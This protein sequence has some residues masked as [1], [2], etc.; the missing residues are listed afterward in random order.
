[1]KFGRMH[2]KLLLLFQLALLWSFSGL[3]FG[4]IIDDISLK[5]DAKGELDAVITF[6]IPIQYLRHFPHKKTQEMVIYFNIS[7]SVSRDQWQNYES[8]RSPPSDIV[9]AVYVSTR[10]LAT[11]PKIRFQFNRPAEFSVAPGRNGQSILV[12][13]KPEVVGKQKNGTSTGLPVGV[14]APVPALPVV[15]AAPVAAP[16]PAPRTAKET[17]AQIDAPVVASSVIASAPAQPPVTA[18]PAPEPVP[19]A[20]KPVAAP[21]ATLATPAIPDM[22]FGGKDGLPFFPKIDP[23]VKET[24]GPQPAETLSLDEQVKKSNNQAAALMT[25]GRD[26]LFKGELFSAIDAFNAVLNLPPNKYSAN[27]QL[28][29]GIAKERSGQQSKARLE[30]ESYLK[31]YPNGAETAW[32][33]Q[34]LAKLHV[35]VPAPTPT[36]AKPVRPQSTKFETNQF[37]SL[38]MYYYRGKSWINTTKSVGGVDVPANSSKTDQSS[39]I[40]LVSMTARAYNNEFDNRLTFQGNKS[41]DFLDD[42]RSRSRISAAYYDVRNRIDNY[43]ARLG[44]QSAMG[45]GVLGRF[46]GISAG[47]GFSPDWR[48]NFSTGQ[49][50]DAVLGQKPRFNSVSLDFGVNSPLGGS[51]YFINQNVEGITD[52]RAAG[53]NLRYFEQGKTVMAMLDYDVQFKLVNIFTLQGT[54]N[55]D[56]GTDYNFMIDHRRTP[57]LTIMDAVYGAG[58]VSASAQ[59]AI[60]PSNP[61]NCIPDPFYDPVLTPTRNPCLTYLTYTYAPATIST[62]LQNGFTIEDLLMLAKK[63]TAISN[64]AQIG[65]SQ[66]VREK[67]QVGGDFSLSNTSGMPESGTDNGDGTTGVEGYFP[68]TPSSGVTWTLSGRVSGSDVIAK[69]DL[70]TV[71][72]SYTKGPSVN[73]T[74]LVLNN[75]AYPADLWTLDG[76]LRGMWVTD[77]Y[78]GKQK[79]YSA[80]ARTG[81]NL[82][83]NLTWEVEFGL[84]WL[85]ITYSTYYPATYTRGY[86]STGFHWN[87]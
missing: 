14:V 12:H 76:T 73:S 49:L 58:S 52:R 59:N 19:E 41:M 50:T 9:R 31:L 83:T 22:R 13:I 8:L 67:W 26:A 44:I 43:S 36:I 11:G 53:G 32:V 71:S 33:T 72:L 35:S 78:G 47:Y 2:T 62:L 60:D 10:D 42:R 30:Y 75:R 21:V 48:A 5:A 45:G 82:K 80:V 15:T 27:A 23:V 64:V 56:S 39:L 37:G 24:P 85:K 28:W 7:G 38:S 55:L 74:F 29:I 87:F 86:A 18:K 4:E 77:I 34:R 68:A 1:M 16:L 51:A 46:L 70:S 84:D 65:V 79:M 54:M 81:Y 17:A 6:N 40:T 61:A 57:S 63:R 25:K 66:R 20:V 69:R 3:A